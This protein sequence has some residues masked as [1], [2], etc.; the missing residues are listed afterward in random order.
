VHRSTRRN[1]RGQDDITITGRMQTN[2]LYL[3]P[4]L[5]LCA[6]SEITHQ[7]GFDAVQLLVNERIDKP[8]EWTE[9]GS[10]TYETTKRIR[11]LLANEL[12]ADTAVELA[13]LNSAALQATFSE[14]GIAQ[15]DLVDASLIDNP[16]LDGELTL[17]HGD[18]V[19]TELS[20]TENILALA[21]LPLRKRIGEEV[22]DLVKLSVAAS[23]L[24]LALD[25][26]RAF[27][28]H[29][30]DLQEIDLRRSAV[31]A[32]G[33][34]YDLVKRMQVAGN[35][36]LLQRDI[37]RALFE[38]AKLDLAASE[39]RALESREQLHVILGLWGAGTDWTMRSSLPEAARDKIPFEGI[40]ATAVEHSLD[41]GIAKRRISLSVAEGQA[42][43][44]LFL[45]GD[46]SAGI[47]TEREEGEWFGGP[48]LSI[49]IPLFNRGGAASYRAQM[50]VRQKEEMLRD[51][52]VQVRARVRAAYLRTESLRQQ[53]LYH[54]QLMIPLRQRIVD[55]T[56]KEFNAMLV[57]A[58][59]LFRAKRGE[60]ESGIQYVRVLRDYWV[61]HSD[62]KLMQQGRLPAERVSGQVA[63]EGPTKERGDH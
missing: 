47:A 31:A 28:S 36:T 11:G 57:G 35:V 27:Y 6:C 1:V 40:E 44:G 56:Q 5:L 42:A 29:Q 14:L 7:K 38:E 33:A 8:I 17:R 52:A 49:P 61:S 2:R 46:G 63:K 25:A 4:L 60:I 3:I 20:L 37:E 13:L 10:R 18:A 16:V 50:A 19:K 30:G 24:D 51:L 22:F 9:T 39:A 48:A 58:F 62:L 45:F 32:T 21:Y 53:A 41:L 15:A 43:R 54:E 59:D 26:R 23:V 34:A 55:E 12:T